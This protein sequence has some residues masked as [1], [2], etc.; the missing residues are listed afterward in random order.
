MSDVNVTL[1][2]QEEDVMLEGSDVIGEQSVRSQCEH[3]LHISIP[4]VTIYAEVLCDYTPI[5]I[6]RLIPRVKGSY[7]T[8][9][10]RDESGGDNLAFVIMVL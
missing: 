2:E 8:D 6:S 10:Q 3:C 4:G 1:E 9:K 5:T 7:S